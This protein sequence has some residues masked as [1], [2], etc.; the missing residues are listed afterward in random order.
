MYL[1]IC[2]SSTQSKYTRIMSP[3]LEHLVSVQLTIFA[4]DM[5][6]VTNS[7]SRVFSPK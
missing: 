4:W 6:V 2:N 3:S 1:G 5:T 7:G